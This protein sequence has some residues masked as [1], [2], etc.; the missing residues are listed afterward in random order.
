MPVWNGE[1]YLPEAVESVLAQ[2]FVD[3][4]LVVVDDGS[5]D[6]TE[7][8][9]RSYRDERVKIYRLAHEGG[10]RFEFRSEPGAGGVDRPAG[11]RVRERVTMALGM[12]QMASL[13]TNRV[14][15]VSTDHSVL[16]EVIG[17]LAALLGSCASR[18]FRHQLPSTAPGR[19]RKR[20]S[21]RQAAT[22]KSSDMRRITGCGAACSKRVNS[23]PCLK[24]C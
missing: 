12:Q 7:E 20:R 6:G 24:N 10:G 1:R 17:P 5:D 15:F 22:F 18:A 14:R 8:I 9:L 23:S 13:K 19:F 2:S 11:C 16:N 21:T 3:F 4:E